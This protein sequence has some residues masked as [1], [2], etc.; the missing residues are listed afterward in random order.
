LQENAKETGT[1]QIG[2]GLVA[3]A[4]EKCL[5]GALFEGI[6]DFAQLGGIVERAPVERF[7]QVIQAFKTASE[8][9][10]EAKIATSKG[11]DGSVVTGNSP[12]TCVPH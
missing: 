6:L 11:N 10:I 5:V 7:F 8:E 2:K 12:A 4:D 3:E 9:M 1:L